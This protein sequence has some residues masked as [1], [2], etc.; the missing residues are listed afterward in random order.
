[1]KKNEA[2]L[3]A[4]AKFEILLLLKDTGALRGGRSDVE[5]DKKADDHCQKTKQ[6]HLR[7]KSKLR[8]REKSK[9][10]NWKVLLGSDIVT[11]SLWKISCGESRKKEE[12]K[13][14]GPRCCGEKTFSTDGPS[15]RLLVVQSV[16]DWD[17]QAKGSATNFACSSASDGWW[18]EGIWINREL[19][20]NLV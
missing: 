1:M 13:Q 17:K 11:V 10:K 20:W 16:R 9:L 14:A 15:N 6:Y 12:T 5:C 18:Q 7:R 3:I 8:Q 4:I 2:A 19:R